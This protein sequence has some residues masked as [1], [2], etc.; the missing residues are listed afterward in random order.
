MSLHS[1]FLLALILIGFPASLAGT[2][3]DEQMIVLAHRAPETGVN[4]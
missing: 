3:I 4:E 2:C 1:R